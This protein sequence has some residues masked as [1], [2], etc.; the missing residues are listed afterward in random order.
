MTMPPTPSAVSGPARRY[1]PVAR[2]LRVAGWNALALLAGLLLLAVGGEVYWRLS[3]PFMTT[4]RT[5]TRF[6]P[7]VSLMR[8]PHAEVR[9]T[10]KLD[11]WTVS[12]TNRFSFLDREPIV[13]RA[14][15]SCHIVAIGDSFVEARQVPIAD[16]F[17]VRLE[18]LAAR[19]APALRITTSAF[20]LNGTGQIN[21][22]PFYDAYARP[23]RP[24]LVVLVFVPNDFVDND[25]ALQALRQGW[26]PDHIPRV[27]ATVETPTGQPRLRPPAPEYAAFRLPLPPAPPRPWLA[28]A[29]RK[30]TE[31]SYF[32]L[33][34]QAKFKAL[35]PPT[36]DPQLIARVE[37]LRQRPGYAPRLEG[38]QPTTIPDME[39][40]FLAPHRPR[41][42]EEALAFTAFALDQFQFRAERDGFSLVILASHAMRNDG[43]GFFAQM[44]A[45]ADAR[46]IPV[47]DQ[48]DYIRRQGAEVQAAYWPHDYHWNAAGHQWAAEALL[49]YLMRH[50]ALCRGAPA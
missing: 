38:W 23:L 32:A 1:G 6:V 31:G 13:Q 41:A 26:G 44:K 10:N 27:S 34:L 39:K 50:P 42:F 22:L 40:V 36:A 7:H 25:A 28:K 12:Y 2:G 43:Y 11:F 37:A 45:M 17:H 46:D 48:F 5:V 8:E 24:K 18:A 3:V 35:F 19:A 9:W 49:E 30:V 16:K 29:W 47:I 20:G 4:Q 14:V 15:N 33:W 21:Q